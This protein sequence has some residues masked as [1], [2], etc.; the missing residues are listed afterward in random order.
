M[1]QGLF[2]ELINNMDDDC[3]LLSVLV[4]W[5]GTALCFSGGLVGTYLRAL[6]KVFKKF[7]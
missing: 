3:N 6:C 2:M 1:L 5:V 4:V 7:L